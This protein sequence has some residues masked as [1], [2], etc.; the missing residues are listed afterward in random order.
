MVVLVGESD[1]SKGFQFGSWK[2]P[3]L[4][5][6]VRE[7]RSVHGLLFGANGAGGEIQP[8]GCSDPGGLRLKLRPSG[9][10]GEKVVARA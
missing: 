4:A 9:K 7:S 2:S 8:D 10:G 1:R 3:V 6:L 5:E